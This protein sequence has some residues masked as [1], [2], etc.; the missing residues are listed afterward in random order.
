MSSSIFAAGDFLRASP[1]KS[2]AGKIDELIA[3]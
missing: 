3:G 1:Q 2:P